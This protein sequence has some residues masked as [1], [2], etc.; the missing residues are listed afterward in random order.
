MQRYGFEAQLLSLTEKTSELKKKLF[1]SGILTRDHYLAIHRAAYMS[2]KLTRRPAVR[3]AIDL[4]CSRMTVVQGDVKSSFTETFSPLVA[5]PYLVDYQTHP[6][7]GKSD[8]I[9]RF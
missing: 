3:N 9:Q 2:T 4:H 5:F 7:D 1:W 6:G 8:T